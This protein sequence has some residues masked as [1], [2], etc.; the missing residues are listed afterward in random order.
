MAANLNNR[1]SQ[2]NGRIELFNEMKTSKYPLGE[3]REPSV[4]RVELD[5]MTGV[6]FEEWCCW[7]LS[8]QGYVNIETTPPTGDFGADIIAEKDEIRFAIQCKRYSDPVGITA[9]E[10]AHS[11]KSYYNCDIA[12]VMASSTFTDAAR[13]LATKTR[14]QLWDR[15]VIESWNVSH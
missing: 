4:S 8:N 12:V 5:S 9:I 15:S 6:E 3:L 1:L 2:I 7:L 10:Q 13:A 14:V 11:A